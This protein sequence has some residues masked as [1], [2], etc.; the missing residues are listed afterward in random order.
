[1]HLAAAESTAEE[2]WR[3]KFSRQDTDRRSYWKRMEFT[4]PQ[5]LGLREHADQ[6]GL[7]FLSSPFSSEAFELLRRI[8]V[9]AWKVASGELS[10]RPM[11]D[12]MIATGMPLLLSTG[13][14]PLSE[15]DDAVGAAQAAQRSV[16]V[17][18]CT[19]AYPCKP[20]DVGLNLLPLFRERYGCPVGLSDHSGT[21]YP[22]LAA[23]TLGAAVIEVHVTLSR[24]MFGPDVAASV[25]TSE[26]RQLTAGVRFIEQMLSHPVDKNTAAESLAP[27]RTLFTKSVVLRESL[28]AGTVLGPEHLTVKKPGTGIP[29]A[30]L[31]TVIGSRLRRR[32]DADTVLR[33]SD[34]ESNL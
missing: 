3:T 14:S 10:N 27:L 28:E 7:L 20:D 30:A 24:E 33:A 22:A 4:E 25:T 16:A 31:A 23:T 1:M 8:G 18:Q 2:G 9:P 29:A 21:I 12:E 15:V 26:L 34:L 6:R 19:T 32:L 13:M 5:W 11:L 17:M